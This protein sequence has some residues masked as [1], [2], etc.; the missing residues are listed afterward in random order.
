MNIKRLPADLEMFVRQEIASGKYQSEDELVTEA[1]R[2]LKDRKEQASEKENGA[3][4]SQVNAQLVAL[5][6]LVR[7]FESLPLEGPD[8]GFSVRDHDKILYGEP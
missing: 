4:T 2:Q 3:E 7:E 5:H 6:D 1:L 8:D